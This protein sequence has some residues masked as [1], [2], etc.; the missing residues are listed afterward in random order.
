VTESR[1]A[2]DLLSA[3]PLHDGRRWGDVAE[4][5]QLEDAEAVL[6]GDQPYAFLTRSR[7]GSKTTD[8]AGCALA[9]MLT[10]PPRSRLYWCAADADQGT[11]A[12]DTIAGFASRTGSLA[13]ALSIQARKVVFE[14]T[15]SSL[16]VLP[17]DA[18]SAWGLQPDAIFVDELANWTDGPAARRL[19]EA[20]SSAAAKNPECRMV[21]LTTAGNPQHFA[22]GVIE[23]AR[24]SPLWHVHEVEGPAPWL[25]RDRLAEQKARLPMA[26][27][28]QLFENRWTAAEGSFLDPAI[29]DAAFSLEA[30][31]LAA[32]G[33][34]GGYVAGLDLG[35][36]K[37]RSVLAIVH[38]QDGEVRLDRMQVWTPTKDTPVDFGEIE[39]FILA[40]HERFGFTLRFDPWQ[41]LDLAQRLRA[42]GVQATEFHFSPGSKQRLAGA[43]LHSMNAGKLRLYDA[44]GLRDELLALRVK[45]TAAGGWTF[46]HTAG[47]HD[48]RAV[49]LSIALVEALEGSPGEVASVPLVEGAAEPAIEG[50]GL[51]HVGDRYLDR[52][53]H[54]EL[55]PPP[56]WSRA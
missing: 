45:Q 19:W 37:D 5:F 20:A 16:E 7:G 48:D 46:D 6:L 21:V 30:P 34:R 31:M 51:R 41:G 43:L 35:H 22:H 1:M 54:G 12:I 53:G 44:P 39:D 13:G 32:E 10:L 11:L 8:L 4:P 27:Y 55:S 49:A 42:A 29:V 15:G 14:R 56:G 24:T 25:D 26:V 9:L 23:H 17:A 28:E 18:P 50:R 2:L 47:G 52:G 38:R 36:S 33:G 3:L 40:A